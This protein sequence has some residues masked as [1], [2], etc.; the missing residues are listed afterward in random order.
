M[1]TSVLLTQ[2]PKSDLRDRELM[3]IPAL[4]TCNG[5]GR[6]PELGTECVDMD[7]WIFVHPNPR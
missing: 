4:S 3:E 1:N 2:L 7:V 5:T 6:I